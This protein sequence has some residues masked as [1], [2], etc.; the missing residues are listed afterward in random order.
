VVSREPPTV[1][2]GLPAVGR[3]SGICILKLA[4]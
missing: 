4:P 2:R 1:G 3:E